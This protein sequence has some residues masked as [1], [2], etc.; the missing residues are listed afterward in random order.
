[1]MLASEQ[2]AAAAVHHSIRDVN[3]LKQVFTFLPGNWLLLG[4]V[5]KEWEAI[6]ARLGDQLVH[7]VRV[8]ADAQCW[9]TCRSKT[10]SYSAA[11]ASPATAKLACVVCAST[12]ERTACKR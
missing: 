12:A 1:M 10:T 8:D 3:I 6:Y 5:C 7:C 9:R 4:A 11:V 2:S